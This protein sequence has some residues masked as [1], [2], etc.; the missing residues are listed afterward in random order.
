MEFDS[1]QSPPAVPPAPEDFGNVPQAAAESFGSV[2][3]EG[4][5]DFGK[6]LQGLQAM[7]EEERAKFTLTVRAAVR[8]FESKGVARSERSITNWCKKNE[9]GLSRLVCRS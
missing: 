6:V 1:S 5:E 7:T 4:A 3:N 8:V 2:R 9:D